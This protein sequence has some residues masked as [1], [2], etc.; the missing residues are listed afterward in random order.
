MFFPSIPSWKTIE[1]K[2]TG[3]PRCWSSWPVSCISA[4]QPLGMAMAMLG[5]PKKPQG[6][7]CTVKSWHVWGNQGLME[8]TEKRLCRFLRTQQVSRSKSL[9]PTQ[10]PPRFRS[11]LNT[12]FHIFAWRFEPMVRPS[13]QEVQQQ[14]ARWSCRC[15]LGE[16]LRLKWNH[17]S[18]WV[19]TIKIYQ[20]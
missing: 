2:E 5:L 16:C 4:Q 12:V 6:G 8:M 13:R 18:I 11:T 1:V 17:D 3:R 19:C 15:H 7:W 14:K 9:N 20:N 10:L